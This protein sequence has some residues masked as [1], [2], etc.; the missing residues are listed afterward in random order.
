MVGVAV[1]VMVTVMV[2]GGRYWKWQSGGAGWCND[3]DDGRGCGRGSGGERRQAT[4]VEM[5]TRRLS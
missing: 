2:A 1:T 3:G 5:V 4:V